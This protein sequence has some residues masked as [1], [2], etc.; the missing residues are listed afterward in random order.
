MTS[1]L[2]QSTKATYLHT[3]CNKARNILAIR[4]AT[5]DKVKKQDDTYVKFS[6]F[7]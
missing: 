1:E 7:L 4:R 3:M 5:E 2:L 6:L